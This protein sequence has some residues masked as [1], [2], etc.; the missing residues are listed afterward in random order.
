MSRVLREVV[1]DRTFLVPALVQGLGMCGMFVYI[2][3]GSFVLQGGYGL[4]A[5]LYA[6]V[7]AVNA[8]GIVL[9]GKLSGTYVERA[10][11]RVLLAVGVVVLVLAAVAMVV[12]V[13]VSRSVWA[14]LPAL[15]VLVAA[16]GLI[17]PNATALA[18]EGQAKAAGTGSAVVGLA[19]FGFGAI[20]PPLASLGGVTPLVM[21]V[22]ILATSAATALVLFAFRVPAVARR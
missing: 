6:L 7:F 16:G 18:L 15:F 13:L 22:T 11:P 20:V 12:G 17:M 8:A 1:R 14:L 21:V 10:G 9:A 4:D 2:A 3:M 5:Q 19:Q